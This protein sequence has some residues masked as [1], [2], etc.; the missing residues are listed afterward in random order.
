VIDTLKTQEHD[1]QDREGRWY[2]LRIRPYRTT[3]NKIDGAVILLV[4]VDEIKRGLNE[5]MALVNQP[6]L[7][8]RGDLR[9]QHANEAFHDVF[10][11]TPKDVENK[12]IYELHDGVWNFG[13]LKNLLEGT[14]P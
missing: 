4:D 10:K 1:V 12:V 6:L 14:L 9:V 7:I 13:A 5:F 2:S 11:T 8:L 3:E